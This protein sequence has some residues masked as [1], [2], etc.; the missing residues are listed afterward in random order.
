VT[1]GPELAE[2]GAPAVILH[3]EGY[4]PWEMDSSTYVIKREGQVL[5]NIYATQYG[6]SIQIGGYSILQLGATQRV[7][8]GKPILYAMEYEYPSR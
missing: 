1:L 5:H 6:L 7:A 8:D 4:G 3:W 2:I